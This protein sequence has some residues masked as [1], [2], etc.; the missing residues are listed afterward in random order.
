MLL[1]ENEIKLLFDINECC[2]NIHEF[3]SSVAS[4]RE[5]TNNKIIKKAIERDLITIGEAIVKLNKIS[6]LEL[7]NQEKIRAFRNRLVHDYNGT[8]DELVW[9]AVIRH[10]PELHNEVKTYLD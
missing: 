1:N 2:V 10:L 5:Y 6:N 8:S 3:I 7:K 4:F 9:I